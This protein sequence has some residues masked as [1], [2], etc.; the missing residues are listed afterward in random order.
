MIRGEN[1]VEQA[2]VV[3]ETDPWTHIRANRF[4]ASMAAAAIC[5]SILYFLRPEVLS[6]SVVGREIPP[7]DLLWNAL[8][9]L[10]GVLILFG[11]AADHRYV[12]G[13]S[14]IWFEVGGLGLFSTALLVNLILAWSQGFS[15]GFITLLWFL[16]P[17]VERLFSLLVIDRTLVPIAVGMRRV[18]SGRKR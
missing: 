10:S 13:I 7:W 3:L 11:L 12:K 1:R 9:L 15:P 4:E 17:T 8:Y 14:G 5:Y 2:C 18:R 16:I 6:R